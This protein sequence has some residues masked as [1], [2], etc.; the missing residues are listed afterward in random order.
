MLNITHHQ[1]NQIKTTMRYHFAPVR[2]AKIKNSK[3]Q[4]NVVKK[5]QMLANALLVD[6]LSGAATVEDGM[7]PPQKIKNKTTLQ[8]RHHTTGSL[9]SEYKNRILI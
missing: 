1:E 8:P 7:E 3:T 4:K 2:I 6:M 5:Q 9:P